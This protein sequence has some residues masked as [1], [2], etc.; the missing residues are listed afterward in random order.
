MQPLGPLAHVAGLQR[1]ID[2]RHDGGVAV[3]VDRRTQADVAVVEENPGLPRGKFAADQVHRCQPEG[4]IRHAADETRRSFD[5]QVFGA[6]RRLLGGGAGNFAPVPDR[7]D[8]QV[9]VAADV[10]QVGAIRKMLRP[11]ALVVDQLGVEDA[12]GKHL[13]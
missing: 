9:F 5:V 12:G 4:S 2:A 7:E 10:E 11:R 8:V 1:L 3:A 6:Q 13:D